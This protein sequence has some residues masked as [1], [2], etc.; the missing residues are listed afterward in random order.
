M[1]TLGDSTIERMTLK[2]L[3][4]GYHGVLDVYGVNRGFGI[5]V[6]SDVHDDAYPRYNEIESAALQ[7]DNE[8]WDIAINPGDIMKADNDGNAAYQTY[9]NRLNV[10]TKHSLNQVYHVPGNHDTTPEDDPMGADYYFKNNCSPCPGDNNNFIGQ[11]YTPVGNHLF[12]TLEI[13][14]MLIVCMGDHNSGEQPGGEKG[15]GTGNV[16]FRASGNIL[17]AEQW[18]TFKATIEN[19]TDKIIIVVTHHALNNTTIGS[20]FGEFSDALYQTVDNLPAGQDVDDVKRRGRISYIDNWEGQVDQYGNSEA[21]N[22]IDLWMQT[23]GQYIDVW[24]HGHYHAKIGEVWN[25]RSRYEQ[26]YGT[27]FINC[28]I[29]N[30][31]FAGV[32]RGEL[33]GRSNTLTIQGNNLNVKTFIHNDPTG[34]IPVG[35]YQPEELNIELKTEFTG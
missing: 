20:G 34:Q 13:G 11:P 21:T 9:L 32:Y 17:R 12:Y 18:E 33:E 22:E 31:W 28:G 2:G 10:F 26:V 25:G 7:M 30:T 1:I 24:L 8:A 3:P 35:Y 19:N 29:I 23:N 14:N 6:F 27:H 4:N 16:N 5:K 15:L